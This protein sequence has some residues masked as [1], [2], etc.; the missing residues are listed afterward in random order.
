MRLKEPLQ[1]MKTLNGHIVMH[2]AMFL[3]SLNV[4]LE[5]YTD[6][7]GPLY[8]DGASLLSDD[9][10]FYERKVFWSIQWGH[11]ICATLLVIIFILKTRDEYILSKNLMLFVAFFYFM[12]ILAA[13]W[14]LRNVISDKQGKLG[15]VYWSQVRR[16]LLLE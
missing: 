6:P 7:A 9:Q 1:S 3:T 5:D 11:F 13:M 2:I 8:E 4:D 15:D 10:K 12:P 16:W 14:V